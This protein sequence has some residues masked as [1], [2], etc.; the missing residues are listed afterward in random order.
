MDKKKN[1]LIWDQ[2][3]QKMNNLSIP[4]MKHGNNE[5]GE[6]WQGENMFTDDDYLCITPVQK[7]GRKLYGSIEWGIGHIHTYGMYHTY[8]QFEKLLDS[9]FKTKDS[10][11]AVKK[12]MHTQPADTKTEKKEAVSDG[13]F[14]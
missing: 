8:E 11:L 12:S 1:L 10:T 14:V 13:C 7:Y 4:N 2:I 5:G 6:S 3:C 9:F